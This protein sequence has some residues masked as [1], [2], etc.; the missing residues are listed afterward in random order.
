MDR[1]TSLLYPLPFRGYVE[2]FGR[3]R[4]KLETI[5]GEKWIDRDLQRWMIVSDDHR[6][7]GRYYDKGL[8]INLA[9]GLDRQDRAAISKEIDKILRD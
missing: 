2:Q 6:I 7:H 4:I 3:Y 1:A 9:K 8:A 5:T